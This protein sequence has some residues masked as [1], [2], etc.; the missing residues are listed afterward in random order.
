MDSF[1]LTELCKEPP[2]R[3]KIFW[4]P[5]VY[6]FGPVI[7]NYGFFPKKLPLNIYLAHGITMFEKPLPH[8]LMNSAPLMF[9]FSP[10]LVNSFRSVSQKPCYCLI[11]P[12][13]FYRRINN[14]A[15]GANAKGT[16]AFLA[17]TT[18]LIED[19]MD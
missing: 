16:L 11:S 4:T 8:E 5:E 3:N 15:R 19:K 1:Q 10:R 2:K 14:I 12:N 7:R 18:P 9:Y 17:H 13:V 6:G